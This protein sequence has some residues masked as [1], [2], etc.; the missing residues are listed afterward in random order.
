[1]CSLVGLEFKYYLVV[2]KIIV[3]SLGHWNKV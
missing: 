1:M 2:N 3:A